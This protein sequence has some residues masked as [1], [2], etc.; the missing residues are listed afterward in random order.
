MV[1]MNVHANLYVKGGKFVLQDLLILGIMWWSPPFVL[2]D[3]GETIEKGG[4][5][6]LNA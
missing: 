5:R 3:L 1:I 4:L 2:D 6:Y